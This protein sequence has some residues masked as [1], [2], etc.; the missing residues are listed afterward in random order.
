MNRSWK[1]KRTPEKTEA[2]RKD[3]R[4]TLALTLARPETTNK[5]TLRVAKRPIRES[6]RGD[7]RVDQA[8]RAGFGDA[9]Y[10]AI[11]RRV[12]GDVAHGRKRNEPRGEVYAWGL[13]GCARDNQPGEEGNLHNLSWLPKLSWAADGSTGRVSIGLAEGVKC[14]L[15]DNSHRTGC[16]IIVAGWTTVSP[17]C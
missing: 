4:P 14:R 5:P 3:P 7:G 16:A 17:R 2:W 12:R 1:R 6:R 9:D 10:R 15:S 13:R 8:E 11:A